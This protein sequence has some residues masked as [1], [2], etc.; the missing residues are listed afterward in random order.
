[1]D[2]TQLKELFKKHGTERNKFDRVENKYSKRHDLHAFILIDKILVD[3]EDQYDI[4]SGATH[5]EIYLNA[6]VEELARLITEEQVI[7]LIRCG[8][9]FTEFGILG[10]FV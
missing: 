4:I 5:D 1:M 9:R 3:L 10:M 8:V 2:T 7:E 6:D